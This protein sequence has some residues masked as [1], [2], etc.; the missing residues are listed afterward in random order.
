[1]M[2]STMIVFFSY[3]SNSFLASFTVSYVVIGSF[4]FSRISLFAFVCVFTLYCN[5]LALSNVLA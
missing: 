2:M 5:V 1:M 3:I 4:L